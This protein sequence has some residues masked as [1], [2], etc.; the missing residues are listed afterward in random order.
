MQILKNEVEQYVDKM[1]KELYFSR[2]QLLLKKGIEDGSIVPFGEKFYQKMNHTY[3]N[4][5][6]VSMH[7]KI[8]KTYSWNR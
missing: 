1:K 6:P 3:V 8:F 2:M 5:L 4:C 7:N